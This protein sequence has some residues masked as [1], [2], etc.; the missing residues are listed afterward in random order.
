MVCFPKC[1][2]KTNLNPGVLTMLTA[3]KEK[4]HLHTYFGHLPTLSARIRTWLRYFVGKHMYH[5]RSPKHQMLSNPAPATWTRPSNTI[6]RSAG[7]KDLRFLGFPL[8][9]ELPSF[10][11]QSEM[12]PNKN[13]HVQITGLRRC[14]YISGVILHHQEHQCF[15]G[16]NTPKKSVLVVSSHPNFESS[17]NA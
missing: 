11:M 2:D 16:R 10:P 17:I 5:P 1:G 14:Q 9:V 3:N 12:A 13:L 15:K 6:A 8:F 4:S 7:C